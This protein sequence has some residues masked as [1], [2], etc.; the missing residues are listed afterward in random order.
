MSAL[1]DLPRLVAD[2]EVDAVPVAS[3]VETHEHQ[4]TDTELPTGTAPAHHRTHTA[5]RH[6]SAR[7]GF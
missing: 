3:P 1:S 7:H 4:P 5:R 2:D 6:I